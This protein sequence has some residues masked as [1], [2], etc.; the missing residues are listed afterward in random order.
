M[1]HS[2]TERNYYSLQWRRKKS[3]DKW[4]SLG[5]EF[6][7]ESKALTEKY[8]SEEN[9]PGAEFRV[10]RVYEVVTPL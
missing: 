8:Y 9:Q 1:A 7:T 10:V 6:L 2:P 3:P 5:V 4:K